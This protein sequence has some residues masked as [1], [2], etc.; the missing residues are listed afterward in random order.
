MLDS[1][2]ISLVLAL[3]SFVVSWQMVVCPANIWNNVAHNIHYLQT[4]WQQKPYPGCQVHFRVYPCAYCILVGEPQ[5]HTWVSSCPSS[6]D[7][8]V[9]TWFHPRL[10]K[11]Q[12]HSTSVSN[13]RNHCYQSDSLCLPVRR[14]VTKWITAYFHFTCVQCFVKETSTCLLQVVFP[15]LFMSFFSGELVYSWAWLSVKSSWIS[16][17]VRHLPDPHTLMT[18]SASVH[19]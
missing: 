6:T 7:S 15:A 8:L 17:L 5:C 3:S 14:A 19:N 10:K 16:R 4:P 2:S 1:F 11:S 12:T 18:N 13:S 9:S